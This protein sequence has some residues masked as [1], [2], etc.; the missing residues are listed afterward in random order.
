MMGL[1]VSGVEFSLAVLLALMAY[2]MY[3]LAR[4]RP[5]RSTSAFA[6][7][8][9]ETASVSTAFPATEATRKAYQRAADGQGGRHPLR[10]TDLVTQLHIFASIQLTD[11]RHHGLILRDA[12]PTLKSLAVAYFHGAACGL[13][14]RHVKERERIQEAAI[15]VIQHALDIGDIVIEQMLSDLTASSSLLHC[16]RNGL[17]GAEHWQEHRFV[18]E[19][20]SLYTSLTENALL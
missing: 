4:L 2:R 11:V 7:A 9:V 8:P 20:Q 19:A 15:K 13:A 16:Y 6:P 12:A 14:Y 18:P 1:I 10:A 17:E 3:S 5:F